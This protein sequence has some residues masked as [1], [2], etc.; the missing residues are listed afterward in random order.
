MK[1]L[2]FFLIILSTFFSL[3][4]IAQKAAITDIPTEGDTTISISKGT[5]A[6]GG[7][8]YE[9]TEGNAEI[10]GEPEIME[11]AARASWLKAC[12][13][14]KKET[15]DLNKDNIV[16]VLNCNRASCAKNETS[17]TLCTSKADYKIKTKIK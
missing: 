1:N 4:A 3:F 7:S 2:K 13:D 11:K 14:W 15:K 8:E 12:G 9:I 6:V 10:T 16:L 17:E 5:K